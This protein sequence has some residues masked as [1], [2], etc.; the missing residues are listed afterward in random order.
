MIVNAVRWPIQLANLPGSTRLT[1]LKKL[2]QGITTKKD[3]QDK[4]EINAIKR[5][6]EPEL[7]TGFITHVVLEARDEERFMLQS[8]YI[9]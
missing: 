7:R 2:S 6:A 5:H 3:S 8:S 1:T 9:L 4:H